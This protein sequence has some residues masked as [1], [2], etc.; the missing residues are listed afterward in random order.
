M[1]ENSVATAL[2][3]MVR[4]VGKPYVWGGTGPRGYDCSGLGYMGYKSAGV[5]IPRATGGQQYAGVAVTGSLLPGD[6]IFPHGGH[7]VWYLGGGRVVEAPKTG[8]NIRETTVPKRWKVRRYAKPPQTAWTE[9][10]LKAGFGV[11]DILSGIGHGLEWGADKGSAWTEGIPII[12]S[13]GD[14][15][16]ATDNVLDA[17]AFIVNPHN[18]YRVALFLMGFGLLYVA[19]RGA[20]KTGADLKGA[21]K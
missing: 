21:I 13:A 20:Q 18:W 4:Q 12:G 5:I 11:G 10:T 15:V 9:E 14:A 7:V 19:L 8:L 1:D 2:A 3:Y 6:A 16:K 17:A